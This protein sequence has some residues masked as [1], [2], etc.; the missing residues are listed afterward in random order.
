MLASVLAHRSLPA[1]LA[2]ALLPHPA[3]LEPGRLRLTALP[4]RTRWIT[5]SG[6]TSDC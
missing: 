2:L 1:A 4:I 6:T 3:V 5:E